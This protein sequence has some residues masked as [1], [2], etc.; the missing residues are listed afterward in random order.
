[1]SHH[2]IDDVK[3]SHKAKMKSMVGTSITIEHPTERASR[4]ASIPTKPKTF[5]KLEG[6]DSKE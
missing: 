3:R 1:M 2:H 6:E 4:I 5:D